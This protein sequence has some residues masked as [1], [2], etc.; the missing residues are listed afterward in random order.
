MDV[1]DSC[2]VEQ[3]SEIAYLVNT[4][5]KTPKTK[6]V[7]NGTCY[8]CG[9]DVEHPKLFCGSHCADDYAKQEHRRK[10]AEATAYL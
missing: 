6:L 5:R 3:E 8:G 1:V 9:E 7:P 4:A 2:F 10:Q